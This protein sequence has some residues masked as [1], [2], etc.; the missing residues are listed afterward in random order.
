MNLIKCLYIRFLLWKLK[1]SQHY[2]SIV[3]SFIKVNKL[4]YI[5]DVDLVLQNR[6]RNADEIVSMYSDIHEMTNYIRTLNTR[7]KENAKV[8][9]SKRDS[10]VFSFEEFISKNGKYSNRKELLLSF[11]KEVQ[12]LTR[13]VIDNSNEQVGLHEY[14]RRLLYYGVLAE[15]DKIM[16]GLIKRV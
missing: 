3:D 11:I 14:N 13:A 4:T 6:P 16:L 7:L 2:E 1:Q 10:R 9:N 15:I 5:L 8:I 12:T